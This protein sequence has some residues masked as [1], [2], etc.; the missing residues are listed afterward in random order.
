MKILAFLAQKT[1]IFAKKWFFFW[2]FFWHPIMKFCVLVCNENSP[3]N[4]QN[5]WKLARKGTCTY[6]IWQ[7]FSTLFHGRPKKVKKKKKY[8]RGP[9]EHHFLSFSYNFSIYSRGGQR[10][11]LHKLVGQI[12]PA[13]HLL[14]TLT[15]WW[16]Y[17][18]SDNLTNIPAI[19]LF[20]TSVCVQFTNP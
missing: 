4:T 8:A 3:I 11:K 1:K 6:F 10:A 20:R 15:I 2:L 19:H 12:W 18:F 14:R 7:E 16:W 5:F 17:S 9:N 13:G